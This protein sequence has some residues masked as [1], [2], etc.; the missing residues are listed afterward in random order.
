MVICFKNVIRKSLINSILLISERLSCW[1]HN[2][3]CFSR[4]AFLFLFSYF[5]LNSLVFFTLSLPFSYP[6]CSIFLFL[7]PPMSSHVIFPLLPLCSSSV[8]LCL[9]CHFIC[10]S[11]VL[12]PILFSNLS[13]FFLS[14]HFPPS[15]HPFSDLP[16]CLYFL[17]YSLCSVFQPFPPPDNPY[18][19][20]HPCLTCLSWIINHPPE[21][22]C[23]CDTLKNSCRKLL[24]LILVQRYHKGFFS[25][26]WTCPLC[27]G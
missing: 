18:L 5:H 23:C 2:T 8:T 24:T 26:C 7:H 13:S 27:W 17:P 22:E 16:F 9:Y 10:Y 6:R 25:G 3:L 15:F 11:L 21:L 4:C 12:S 1:I 19:R 20:P 14:D